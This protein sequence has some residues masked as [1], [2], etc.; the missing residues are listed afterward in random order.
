[1]LAAIDEVV[2]LQVALAK[3]V[4]AMG[5]KEFPAKVRMASPNLLRMLNPRHN[6]AQ[7][8]LNRLLKPF[9]LKL[10]LTGQ[11]RRRSC[12][13]VPV[14]DGKMTYSSRGR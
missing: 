13:L 10:S 5:V 1:L 6:P 7:E 12:G 8:T 3:V 14:F 9:R 4:R 11:N 2:P